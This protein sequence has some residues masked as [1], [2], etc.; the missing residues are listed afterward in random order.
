VNYLKNLIKWPKTHW[1]TCN[2]QSKNWNEKG[3][4]FKMTLVGKKRKQLD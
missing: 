4:C 2:K 3:I 1:T